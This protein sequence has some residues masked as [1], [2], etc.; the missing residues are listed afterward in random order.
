M[1]PRDLKP[2]E[3]EKR[4]ALTEEGGCA[5]YALAGAIAI[6]DQEKSIDELATVMQELISVPIGNTPLA[7]VAREYHLPP[8]LRSDTGTVYAFRWIRDGHGDILMEYINQ[9]FSQL[10]VLLQ[11]SYVY[12]EHITNE[13][14]VERCKT[15]SVA[16]LG[17]DIT[18][19]GKY[20]A[21]HCTALGY[22][23]KSWH[24][25]D[26]NTSVVDINEATLNAILQK[27]EIGYLRNGITIRLTDTPVI[28]IDRI[29]K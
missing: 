17:Y 27:Q 2:H 29:E 26:I 6:L 5:L 18:K 3:L 14:L 7:I 28:F 16:L 11:A 4:K 20:T 1:D 15:G 13:E 22:W 10:H 25:V 19:D 23:D 8:P 21:S 12:R 9:R 24:I